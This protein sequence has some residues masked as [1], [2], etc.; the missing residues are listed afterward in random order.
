MKRLLNLCGLCVA[1]SLALVPA[2]L[3][4]DATSQQSNQEQQTTQQTTEVSKDGV[5][6]TTKITTVEGKVIRYEPGKTIV[7]MGPD[8]KEV[9]YVLSSTVAAPGDI[10][11]G[12]VVS[13]TTQPSDSGPVTVTRITTT[14]SV[15]P[16]GS[17]K[18]ETQTNTTDASG[19]QTSM[20]T[21]SITGTV[22]AFDPGKS[23]TIVLPDKKTVV[24]TVDSSSVVPSDLAVGKS[25]TVQ[26]VRTKT[27]GP[28][29]VRKITTTKETTKKTTVQ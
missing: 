2:A 9:S 19:N 28:L 7:L 8:N 16:D 25:Y 14:R 20:K 15:N 5:T 23:V 6:Q 29:V 18:T 1:G 4:Q 21:T 27:D 26:V 12:R 17:V 13:L 22:S 24:Y 10:Q 3:A 11:V